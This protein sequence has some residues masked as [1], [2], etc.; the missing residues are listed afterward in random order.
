MESSR[1]IQCIRDQC[2]WITI[3]QPIWRYLTPWHHIWLSASFCTIDGLTDE[4]QQNFVNDINN[5]ESSEWGESNDEDNIEFWKKH[6]WHY[7]R[8]W[9]RQF[10]WK[11][12]NVCLIF[13]NQ[14]FKVR[15]TLFQ[16]CRSTLKYYW[17]H[18]ENVTK[19]KVGFSTLHNVDTTSVS[20]QRRKNVDTTFSQCFTVASTLWEAISKPIGLVISTDFQIGD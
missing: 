16:Y 6:N 2:F 4:L 5:E 12:F 14:H 3:Y 20:K 7:H 9:I 13:P 19:S 1:D 11:L 15:S 8:W 18:V 10:Y 17:S